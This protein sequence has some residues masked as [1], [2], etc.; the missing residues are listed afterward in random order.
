MA[1]ALF[2]QA[3]YDDIV[4]LPEYKVGEVIGGMLYVQPR[5]APR[6]VRSS[7]RLGAWLDNPFDTGRN[8][9]GGWW[10]LDEPELHLGADVLVPDLA[11]WRREAMPKLP[12]TAWFEQAPNWVAEILSPSTAR[13]DRAVKMPKYA[14]YGVQHCWLIDPDARTLEA[15]ENRAGLWTLLG[16][17]S[18]DDAAAAAPFE[19]VAL[20]LA[21]LWVD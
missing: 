15:Y 20:E 18:G 21:G 12:E 19:A 10:I 6:H 5:P 2:K 17:W 9:P 3:T 1:E 4:A 11:G 13:K 16:V 14:E 8:G 7:S